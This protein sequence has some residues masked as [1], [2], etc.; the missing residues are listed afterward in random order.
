LLGKTKLEIRPK[1]PFHAFSHEPNISAM[2]LV[3]GD[4]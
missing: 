3:S 2:V 4:V 1:M